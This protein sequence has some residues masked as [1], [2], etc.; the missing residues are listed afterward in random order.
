MPSNAGLGRGINSVRCQFG[1]GSMPSNSGLGRGIN[2]FKCR[3]GERDQ[4]LQI[5]VW[6]EGSMSSNAGLGRGIN[7]FKCRFGERDQCLQ[8]PVWG[9]RSMS[10]KGGLGTSELTKEWPD[11]FKLVDVVYKASEHSKTMNDGGSHVLRLIVRQHLLQHRQHQRTT[12][13]VLPETNI[14]WLRKKPR[15]WRTC[16]EMSVVV[17][18]RNWRNNVYSRFSFRQTHATMFSN[19]KVRYLSDRVVWAWSAS[20]RGLRVHFVSLKALPHVTISSTISWRCARRT[21]S[22]QR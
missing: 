16:H 2:I 11:L 7:A 4:C 10:S 19:G 1:E 6:G 13:L 14:A 15:A 12:D 21:Q 20:F 3:F 18:V 17:A 8:M 5:V 9:E 22:S